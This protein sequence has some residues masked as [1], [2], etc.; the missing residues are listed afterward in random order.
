MKYWM[1]I[2][3]PRCRCCRWYF[4]TPKRHSFREMTTSELVCLFHNRKY[5][6]STQRILNLLRLH[7]GTCANTFN[8]VAKQSLCT[9]GLSSNR[10]LITHEQ[11]DEQKQH[12]DELQTESWF[13]QVHHVIQKS[14]IPTCDNR[15]T[16]FELYRFICDMH[17]REANPPPTTS[18][19]K[20]TKGN[21]IAFSFDMSLIRFRCC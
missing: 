9:C 3:F 10:K 7:H 17:H 11:L 16:L 8:Q 14:I 20:T 5:A 2:F 18:V 12:F 19:R 1:K 15:S 21:E 6:S 13:D 4:D